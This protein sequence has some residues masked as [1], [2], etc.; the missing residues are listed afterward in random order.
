MTATKANLINAIALIV[1]SLWAYF[2][3]GMSSETTLIPV[4]FGVLLLGHHLWLKGGSRFALA[5]VVLLTLIIAYALWTPLS[6]S[7]DKGQALPIIRVG[8]MMATSVF[9]LITLIR[10]VILR[11]PS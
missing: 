9:A 10:A 3:N 1:L 11:K 8:I 7:I 2:A 5:I 6:S 4:A